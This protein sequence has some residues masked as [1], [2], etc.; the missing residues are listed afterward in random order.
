MIEIN[1]SKKDLTTLYN[2]QNHHPHHVVRR[3]TSILIMKH[4]KTPHHQIAAN[5]GVC[6]NTV[7]E[8]FYCYLEKGIA[9]VTAINFYK[10]KSNLKSFNAIITAHFDNNPPN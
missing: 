2:L 6:E 9:D 8:R 3:R 5:A 4:N 7:R 1:F 10:P